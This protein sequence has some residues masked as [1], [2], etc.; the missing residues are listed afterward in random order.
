M[1]IVGR[2]D[3]A[4]ARQLQLTRSTIDRVAEARLDRR[5]IDVAESEHPREPDQSVVVR[6]PRPFDAKGQ[7]VELVR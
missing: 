7:A 2:D 3:D 1:P 4:S 5:R 6:I